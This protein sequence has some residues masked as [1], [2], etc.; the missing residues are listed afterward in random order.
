MSSSDDV[1]AFEGMQDMIAISTAVIV[2]VAKLAEEAETAGEWWKAALRWNALGQMKMTIA[3]INLPGK[4]YL[5]K[6][7]ELL[8][9][10]R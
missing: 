6:A 2:P 10:S 9:C 4:E 1:I 3:G 8:I 7:G 5:K